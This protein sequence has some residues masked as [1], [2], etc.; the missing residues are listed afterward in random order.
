MIV[1]ELEDLSG[2]IICEYNLAQREIA[3][4]L[5]NEFMQ[6]DERKGT[7]RDDKILLKPT[8]IRISRSAIITQFLENIK[9]KEILIKL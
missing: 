8:N 9:K 1:R 7:G 4:N 2:F 3:N 5:P 6:M